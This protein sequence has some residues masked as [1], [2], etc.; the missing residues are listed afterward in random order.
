ML[1]GSG[2][3]DAGVEKHRCRGIGFGCAT[4]T[5][6]TKIRFHIEMGLAFDLA[7]YANRECNLG[8][9]AFCG[10]IWSPA[11]RFGGVVQMKDAS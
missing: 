5:Q 1:T 4:R 10:V 11:F 6:G 7:V 2:R 9:C 8:A 3:T